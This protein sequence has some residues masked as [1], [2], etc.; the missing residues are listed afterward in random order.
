MQETKAPL[1]SSRT[2]SSRNVAFRDPANPR[3]PGPSSVAAASF[4]LRQGVLVRGVC[5]RPPTP[6]R[7]S[8]L[9]SRACGSET[10]AALMCPAAPHGQ[11]SLRP[12]PTPHHGTTFSSALSCPRPSGRKVRPRGRLLSGGQRTSHWH[13]GP[14][15]SVCS[16]HR[17][18]SVRRDCPPHGL[19]GRSAHPHLPAARG[20]PSG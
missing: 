6:W 14:L 20:G 5:V 18:E 2:E 8:L 19:S 15:A 3:P 10:Q 1:D 16:G 13:C 11:L 9:H 7:A 4:V 12:L 17:P